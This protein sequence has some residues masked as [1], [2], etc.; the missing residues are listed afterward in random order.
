M[1]PIQVQTI[2]KTKFG[3]VP[4]TLRFSLLYHSGISKKVAHK[5]GNPKYRTVKSMKHEDHPNVTNTTILIGIDLYN[6]HR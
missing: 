2:T 5:R 3:G 4:G 1:I 6:F